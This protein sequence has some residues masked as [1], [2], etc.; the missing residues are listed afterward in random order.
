VLKLKMPII[1]KEKQYI[2]ENYSTLTVKVI[3]IAICP[4]VAECVDTGGEL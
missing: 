1:R 3:L 4:A 2:R